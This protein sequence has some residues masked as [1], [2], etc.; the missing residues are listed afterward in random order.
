MSTFS[1]YADYYNLLYSNKDY[2]SETDFIDRIIKRNA[3]SSKTILNL[4]CGTGK[5]D[6]LLSKLGY[7]VTGVDLSDEMLKIANVSRTNDQTIKNQPLFIKG[8]IRYIQLDKQFDV[9]T[10]L[11]H[12]ISYLPTNKDIALA[13]D[14]VK[15]HLKPGGIFIF[16]VWYGPAVLTCKPEVRFKRM[17]N[18]KISV[19]RVAEPV[20]YHETNI[21][22]VN[23]TVFVK[24]KLNEQYEEIKET[25]KMRY[26][27]T[28]ELSNF[29]VEKKISILF[30]AE[31][32]SDKAP[33]FDTWGVYFV[34]KNE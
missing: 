17:E 21:V 7:E 5:H 31:W 24:E 19:S 28:P 18:E 12:V 33:G 11:F 30:S 26:F 22:D 23:Y 9:I 15:K 2:A 27:F 1:Y 3:L 8:D 34:A 29:L 13:F 20:I 10:A 4:G 14:T 25:H 32:M 6:F 16:D